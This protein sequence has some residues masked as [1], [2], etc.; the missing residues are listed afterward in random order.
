MNQGIKKP[1]GRWFKSSRCQFLYQR[2]GTKRLASG[3][4]VGAAVLHQDPLDG[5]AANGAKFASPMSNLKIKMGCA[6]LTLG[7]NVG[8]HASAFAHPKAH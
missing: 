7:A 3:A 5:A 2:P 4:E 8:I 6:Q 1:F